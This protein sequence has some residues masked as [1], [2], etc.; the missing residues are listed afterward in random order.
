MY[1]VYKRLTEDI[2]GNK[3]IVYHRTN[4]SDLINK[5]YTDGF[6]PS[7]SIG[8]QFGKGFYAT[9]DLESQQLDN[10]D[11][12]GNIIVKFVVN[13]LNRFFFFDY[14]EFLKSPL[15]KQLKSN[16]E[17]FIEDQIKHFKIDYPDPVE[18]D[19]GDYT[20]K[21]ARRMSKY[22]YK[23]VDGIVYTVWDYGKV[24]LS[25]NTDLLI[26]SSYSTDKGKTF[27]QITPKNMEYLKKVFSQNTHNSKEFNY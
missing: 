22:L 8:S 1:R 18:K 21:L 24:L 15:A 19:T 12:F 27:T 4:V 13:S 7:G 26:P 25:Y 20:D 10:M 11:M 3:A 5:V 9:Y 17:T 14:S 6:K 23:K 2:Y 16:E